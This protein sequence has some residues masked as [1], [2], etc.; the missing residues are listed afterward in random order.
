VKEEKRLNENLIIVRA[1]AYDVPVMIAAYKIFF[2]ELLLE[3]STK[4][5]D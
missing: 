4:V 3:E 5:A 1:P 2:D